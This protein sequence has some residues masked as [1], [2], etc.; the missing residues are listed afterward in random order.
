MKKNISKNSL[1]LF[2]TVILSAQGVFAK[3]SN[4]EAKA[5]NWSQIFADEIGKSKSNLGAQCLYKSD[6]QYKKA[7]KAMPLDKDTEISNAD[8]VSDLSKLGIYASQYNFNQNYETESVCYMTQNEYMALRM[9]TGSFYTQ[10][11]SALRNLDLDQIKN[12]RLV[13]KFLI[14]ALN[15]LENYVGVTKR[16]TNLKA[17][18]ISECQAGAAFADR[19]F[20]STSVGSGFGGNY[21]F[22]LASSSCKYVAPF[23][24]YPNEEE[25]LCLPGTVFQ[26]RYYDKNLGNGSTSIILQEAGQRFDIDDLIETLEQ[27]PDVQTP[28]TGSYWTQSCQSSEEIFDK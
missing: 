28:D 15:K 3:A 14:N 13:I 4:L 18:T 20:L 2:A 24:S 7:K 5:E 25:V 8:F 19:G 11:N 22:I 17:E 6:A 10:I 27:H 26:I 1:V 16:G 9:Y 21:R 23:S 12:Y